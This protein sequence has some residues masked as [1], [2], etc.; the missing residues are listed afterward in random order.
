MQTTSKE[1]RIYKRHKNIWSFA[2]HCIA[3]VILHSFKCKSEIVGELPEP[4]IVLPNHCC[5]LDPVIVG[6]SFPHHMYFVASEHVYRKGIIS[7][8]L[9]Y[10]FGPIAKI[11]GASDKMMVLKVLKSIREK[12]N[13]C[14]F[15][16]G[17][18]TF[19]GETG[20]ISEAIGKLIRVSGANLVTYKI[21]GGYF[22]NPRW[23][24][25]IR[26]GKMSGKIQKV[27]TKEELSAMTP[28]QITQIIRDDLY[29]NAYTRQKTENIRYKGKKLAE[30]M[31]CA[32][33]VCPI[34]K[35]INTITTKENNINCIHCG[36]LTQYNEYG[37]FENYQSDFNF[38]TVEEWNIW[39]EEFYKKLSL[40]SS[41]KDKPFFIDNEVSLNTVNQEHN[42]QSLGTGTI[43]LSSQGLHFSSSLK[44]FIIPIEQLPDMAMYGKKGL[45]FTDAENIHYELH[46]EKLINV[47]KYISVWKYLRNKHTNME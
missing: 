37:Y 41:T 43:S 23:G 5:D 31:E 21:T 15:P 34:C 8:L 40:T 14:I 42:E 30:G 36:L 25:G 6:A 27:Y 32:L 18:R 24:Y 29:E 7:K 17:D 1:T 11:K 45:V 9:L 4:Y 35:Q 22:T 39:Q 20:D 2:R 33:C 26:K 3:P 19:T 10:S 28:E 13:V 12:K 16:E 44:D 46:C 47:R 38:K